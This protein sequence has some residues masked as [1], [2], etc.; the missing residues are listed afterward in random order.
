MN[1]AEVAAA[2]KLTAPNHEPIVDVAKY[3]DDIADDAV[4]LGNTTL[5]RDVS[6]GGDAVV[7]DDCVLEDE[8]DV[9]IGATLL[10]GARIGRAAMLCAGVVVGDDVYIPDKA[11]IGGGMVIPTTHAIKVIGPIGLHDDIGRMVTIHG[12][13]DGK[14][15]FSAGCQDSVTWEVFAD[16]IENNTQ[17]SPDSAALYQEYVAAGVFQAIGTVVQGHYDQSAAEGRVD[18]IEAEARRLHAP[19]YDEQ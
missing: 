5:G 3:T 9:G 11:Q 1:I 18:W 4:F 15:R 2:G 10:A 19:E 13:P 6:V 17:T 7:E 14:P 8:A 16:R 12:G